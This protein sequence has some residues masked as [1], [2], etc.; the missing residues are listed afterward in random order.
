V[1]A[2]ASGQASVWGTKRWH[3]GKIMSLQEVVIG[4]VCW[5]QWGGMGRAWYCHWN[6]ESRGRDW[7]GPQKKRASKGYSPPAE[8]GGQDQSRKQFEVC[9]RLRARTGPN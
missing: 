7:S 2:L 3:L 6:W 4:M 8:G 9:K 5:P 1:A